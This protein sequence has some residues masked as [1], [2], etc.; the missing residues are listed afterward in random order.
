MSTLAQTKLK[1]SGVVSVV[2]KDHRN[3]VNALIFDLVP[4]AQECARMGKIGK[5][6]HA[7]R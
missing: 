1:L 7:E 2:A 6:L 4:I 5:P 3:F